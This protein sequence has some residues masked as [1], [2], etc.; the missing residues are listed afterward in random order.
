MKEAVIV[1]AVRTAVGKSPKGT[2]KNT[3]PD[4]LGAAAIKEAVARVPSHRIARR[5]SR[6]SGSST[7][8]ITWIVLAP[9]TRAASSR[10]TGTP[11][12]KFFAS[13]IANGSDVAPMKTATAARESIKSSSANNR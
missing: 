11:S 10:E 5:S 4:D 6:T 8:V 1:S 7:R 13:Q 9:S 12:M 2:L 3:R